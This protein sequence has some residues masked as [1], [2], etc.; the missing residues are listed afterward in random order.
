MEIIHRPVFY[1]V[2]DVSQTG[3]WLRIHVELTQVGL[4]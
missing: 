2:D 4:K 1:L 3:F